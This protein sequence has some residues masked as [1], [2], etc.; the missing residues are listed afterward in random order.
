M[1]VK[2]DP[3]WGPALNQHREEAGYAQQAD[4]IDEKQRYEDD[5]INGGIKGHTV[6]VV[7]N[8]V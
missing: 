3:L 6:G 5:G 1:S 2:P 8:T 4:K 7:D